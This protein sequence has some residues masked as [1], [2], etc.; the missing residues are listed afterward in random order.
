MRVAD[1]NGPG[2]ATAYVGSGEIVDPN[3]AS[4]STG[5]TKATRYYTFAGSTV[6]VRTNDNKLSL[7]L[8]D[9][10]GSTNVMMPVTVQTGGAL[11][12]ATLADAQASTR[13]SYTP[14]GQL[15]GAD[16]LAV[17]RGCLGQVED[18][19]V[20]TGATS[21]GTGLTYLNARYF[22][23]ATSRFISPDPL[24]NPGDPK[25]LD[26]YR[27]ADNN[28]VVFTDATGLDPH[29]WKDGTAVGVPV[30]AGV[31]KPKTTTPAKPKWYAPKPKPAPSGTPWISDALNDP[32][33]VATAQIP[34]RPGA[35]QVVVGAFIETKT[36]GILWVNS[37]GD[38]RGFG[39]DQTWAHSRFA[40]VLD[41]ETGTAYY[42]FGASCRHDTCKY[43]S[44]DGVRVETP[45]YGVT[46]MRETYDCMWT[47]DAGSLHGYSD[48]YLK[49]EAVEV[50]VAA[51]DPVVDRAPQLNLVVTVMAAGNGNV[52]YDV[53]G[54]SYPSIEAYHIRADGTIGTLIQS[55]AP[56]EKA[57][58]MVGLLVGPATDRGHGIG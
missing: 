27:Y 45:A 7:M 33:H 2:T 20:G 16:N 3:T 40:A 54:D 29:L 42:R 23:P 30:V 26:P 37:E 28:H 13:T 31:A 58:W 4:T 56:F 32:E 44:L 22:D 5:D 1:A 55:H 51:S 52:E 25:T 6:A 57:G 47:C 8:G 11:A 39:L 10:Q 14:Y 9:E 15:R 19:V 21:T 48:S 53:V 35:G 50:H 34:V 24:M 18:R 17:D 38:N 36:A 12:S 49:S 43:A 46:A 41:F